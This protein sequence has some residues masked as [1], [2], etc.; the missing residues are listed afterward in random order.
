MPFILGLIDHLRLL[1]LL[2]CLP[3]DHCL[4]DFISPKP[5]R[6]NGVFPGARGSDYAWSIQDIV[7]GGMLTDFWHRTKCC[8]FQTNM[9]PLC[10]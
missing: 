4:Q 1:C 5:L 3:H 8:L 6:L 10:T 2:H 9:V 7:N